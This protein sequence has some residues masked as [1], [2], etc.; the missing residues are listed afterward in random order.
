L[1]PSPALALLFDPLAGRVKIAREGDLFDIGG[2]V[3]RRIADF[4]G[5]HNDDFT[6]GL[7]NDGT[8]V[9]GLKFADNT[10]GIFTAM[11][12]IPEPSTIAMAVFG[13]VALL[14]VRR[15]RR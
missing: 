15:H 6:N 13:I 4:N 3:M 10:S 9:F 7:G 14:L 8:L 11:V 5:G 1:V 12:P 2:G